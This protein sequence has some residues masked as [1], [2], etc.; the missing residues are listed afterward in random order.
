MS[1]LKIVMELCPEDRARLDAILE[2]LKSSCPNCE[3]CVS[4][5]SESWKNATAAQHPVDA[6]PPATMEDA[7]PGTAAVADPAPDPAPEEK[8]YTFEEVR[9]AVMSASR[10][11]EELKKKVKALLN[12]YAE[13]VPKLQESDYPAFMEGLQEVVAN[14]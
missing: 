14:G 12:Q 1:E 8:K 10:K 13:S 6:A 5:M 7:T 11:S 9:R 4:T 3:R 2:E